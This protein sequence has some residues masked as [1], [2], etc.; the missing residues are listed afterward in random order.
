L[1]GYSLFY[2]LNVKL[3]ANQQENVKWPKSCAG[4]V[5]KLTGGHIFVIV[6]ARII[7]ASERVKIF[8]Q[9]L[10]ISSTEVSVWSGSLSL[11]SQ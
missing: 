5:E 4:L 9:F 10:S 3:T 8:S 6:T 2:W 1:A 7:H 11:I